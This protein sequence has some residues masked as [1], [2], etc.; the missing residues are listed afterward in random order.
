MLV[1][2][3]DVTLEQLGISLSSYVC[4][5]IL[6]GFVLLRDSLYKLKHF[7][8]FMLRAVQLFLQLRCSVAQNIK[9]V[10]F[11]LTA[12]RLHVFLS[13]AM[14]CFQHMLFFYVKLHF[15]KLLIHDL[16]C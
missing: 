13:V 15:L 8:F 11:H 2:L 7:F 9:V 16:Y 6:L 5:K 10:G 3:K 1:H 12:Q 14:S 4:M